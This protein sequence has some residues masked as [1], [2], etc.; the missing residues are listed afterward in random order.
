MSTTTI[1]TDFG[2]GGSGL[3]PNGSSLTPSLY[4]L[5]KEHKDHIDSN[6]AL[7]GTG[8]CEEIASSG[9]VSITKRTTRFTVSGTK[10]WTL[11][12]GTVAGQ[13]KTLY[14]VSQ[15]STPVGV[16][17]PAHASGF[18]TLTMG[19]SSATASIELE[20]DSSLGT[21]AWKIVGAAGTITVA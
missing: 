21:P 12:D 13:R 4:T 5:L 20:W 14:C 15:A 8:N 17:T 6:E 18:T 11:A 9:A 19:T 1:P 16:V 10:A 7:S 2:S 3:T